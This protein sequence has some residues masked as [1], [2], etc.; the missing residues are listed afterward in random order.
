MILLMISG[1]ADAGVKTIW[2]DKLK[3]MANNQNSNKAPGW[4]G[5]ALPTSSP[6]SYVEF[7][8]NVNLP[9][10]TKIT[11]MRYFHRGLGSDPL[12]MVRLYRVKFGRF[13]D[14]IIGA[15]SKDGNDTIIPVD[16]TLDPSTD[17]YVRRGFRYFLYIVSNNSDSTMWGVKVF[18]Q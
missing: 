15:E 9:V 5:S 18:Y 11:G 17:R 3:P 1:T 6:G 2:P 16:G 4:A 7:Y 8:A 12:T 10:G 13:P 14:V